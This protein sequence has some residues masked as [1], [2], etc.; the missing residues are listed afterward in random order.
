MCGIAG[1]V[2]QASSDHE[3]VLR[4][5]TDRMRRRG[6]DGSGHWIS[7]SA[8]G[9]TAALGH[10]R[11]S[12]IDI[13]GGAQPLGNESGRVQVTFNGE[14]FNF[15]DLRRE[16]ESKGACFRTRSDTEVLLKHLEEHGTEGLSRLNGMFAF[17]IWN[18]DGRE[19]ILARDRVG[20]KPLYYSRLPDGGIAFASELSALI[21]HSEISRKISQEALAGYFFSDYVHAPESILE[22]VYKLEPGHFLRWHDGKLSDPTPF[23]KLEIS[24]TK[25]SLNRAV[26][27]LQDLLERSVE[28]QLIADVPVGIFLS[29]GIDSSVV[30]AL[31]RKKAGASVRTF[32][33]AFE[34]KDFDESP[35]ARQV[36]RHLGTD[37]HEEKLSEAN[38]L[39]S[40]DSALD[41]LDEPNADPS[42]LPTYLLSR[43]TVK[44]VKVALG[45]D[46]GDELFAGY[47]TYKAHRYAK[48][49][50]K[51]PE[52]VRKNLIAEA[53]SRLPVNLG[54][55]SFE[56][57]AKRFALRWD[58][59]PFRR[60]LR[61]MS[62]TDLPDLA[63]ALGNEK[64]PWVLWGL[65]VPESVDSLNRLLALDFQTYLPGSV[66]SKVDRAS[67][68]NSLEVRPPFLD[69]EVIRW[70]FALSSDLKLNRDVSKYVLKTM[71]R[72]LLPTEIVDRPKK[73]FAIPLGRWLRGPLSPRLDRVLRDSPVWNHMNRGIFGQWAQEHRSGQADRS[74]P[75]WSLLVLDHWMRKEAI[76]G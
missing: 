25:T 19:L 47:P 46:G 48:L 4:R 34:D 8:Q 41:C 27:E 13:E 43:L 18:Q 20:I 63:R 69:N 2:S 35:Y 40:L 5:M 76:G 37:H 39:E 15:L 1:F 58:Q 22:G 3:P 50:E 60:H 42:I 38:L 6:P 21:Q 67:M 73:G 61:W 12:I 14:I 57:K 31:A 54:Y 17:G 65:R 74:K 72:K 52:T 55:Q 28:R 36:A 7:P 23:W 11:L 49:Y 56:W 66:L 33:I 53:V 24:E 64:D 62:A 45:G 51:I 75:L 10:R 9:W 68:A 59:D 30:A 16:L 32:S 70:A 71:A 29:G 44:S 26:S